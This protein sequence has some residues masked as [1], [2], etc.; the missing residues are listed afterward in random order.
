MSFYPLLAAPLVVQVHAFLA[1]GTVALTIAI[2]SL[3]KGSRL[4][5]AFGWAWVIAMGSV[6][7][8]SF[9]INDM[10]WLGPFGP[11]HLL[12]AFVLFSLVRGVF[13]ARSGNVRTHKRTMQSLTFGAL[14]LAGAFTLV[15]GRIMFQVVSGG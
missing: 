4:H 15:P 5:R 12:S 13:A 7:V 10:R 14:V 2:F 6:A 1:L 9:W 11:I 8:S 3:R